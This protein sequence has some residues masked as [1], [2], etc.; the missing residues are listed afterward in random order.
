MHPNDVLMAYG[1]LFLFHCNVGDFSDSFCTQA[2]VIPPGSLFEVFVFTTYTSIISTDYN[3]NFIRIWDNH[4]GEADY[5]CVEVKR[6]EIVGY[7]EK[8]K[9][10]YLQSLINLSVESCSIYFGLDGGK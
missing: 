4:S 8:Q 9:N 10:I 6:I 5:V 3:H 7:L 1:S 2:K